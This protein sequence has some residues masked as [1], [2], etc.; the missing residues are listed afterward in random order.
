MEE[1]EEWEDPLSK[2]R[3]KADEHQHAPGEALEL[4]DAS[5]GLNGLN[6]LDLL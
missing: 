2:L 4:L 6:V 5:Q 3:D 1:L